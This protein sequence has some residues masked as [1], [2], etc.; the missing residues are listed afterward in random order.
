VTRHL[1]FILVLALIVVLGFT[2]L[3]INAAPSTLITLLAPVLWLGL[4]ALG[5]DPNRKRAE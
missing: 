4:Y 2:N 1:P 3:S 5:A